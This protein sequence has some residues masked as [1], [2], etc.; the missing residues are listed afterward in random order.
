MRALKTL[1][2]L[3]HAYH[4][5]LYAVHTIPNGNPAERYAAS[6][7]LTG[8]MLNVPATIKAINEFFT[9]PFSPEKEI[10]FF[11]LIPLYTEE[12]DFKLKHGADA[13]L[14]KLSKAG[15]TDIINIDRKNSCKKRFGLF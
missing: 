12:M 5:W 4:T 2:R 1:A 13:L 7:K 3:P 11:N 6:T 9:L 14:D 8:M 15:V 10:H